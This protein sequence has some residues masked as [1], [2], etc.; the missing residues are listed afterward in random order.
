MI[1]VTAC[2]RLNAPGNLQSVF[3]DFSLFDRGF[4]STGPFQYNYTQV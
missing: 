1:A 4:C 3:V 2:L